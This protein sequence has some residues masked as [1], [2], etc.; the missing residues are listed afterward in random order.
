VSHQ[1]IE[2]D[3]VSYQPR[4]GDSE[5]QRRRERRQWLAGTSLMT[6]VPLKFAAMALT[7]PAPLDPALV[8]S[9]HSAVLTPPAWLTEILAPIDHAMR[10]SGPSV[11]PAL[12]VLVVL[13]RLWIN[14]GRRLFKPAGAVRG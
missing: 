13:L 6:A 3:V 10:T 8:D 11:L 14:V 1:A 2:V 7:N 4:M 9:I 5:T 12:V